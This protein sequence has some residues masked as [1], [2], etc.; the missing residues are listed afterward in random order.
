MDNLDLLRA[1][2]KVDKPQQEPTSMYDLDL[3]RKRI[4][5]GNT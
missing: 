3:M 5:G 1:R 4:L 2:I